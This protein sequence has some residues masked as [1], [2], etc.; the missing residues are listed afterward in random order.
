MALTSHEIIDLHGGRIGTKSN[1]PVSV[2]ALVLLFIS[3]LL[4]NGVIST[5]RTLIH[6]LSFAPIRGLDL[7]DH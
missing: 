6:V 7:S 5:P 3:I 2:E 1:V 4:D